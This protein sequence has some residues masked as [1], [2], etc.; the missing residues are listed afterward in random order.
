MEG[1][2]NMNGRVLGGG[3]QMSESET[4]APMVK[5]AGPARMLTG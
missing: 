1:I 2:S 5:G 3:G 4:F